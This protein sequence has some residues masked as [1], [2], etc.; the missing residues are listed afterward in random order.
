MK[1]KET[2]FERDGKIVFHFDF[3]DGCSQEADN[4]ETEAIARATNASDTSINKQQQCLTKD[5]GGDPDTVRHLRTLEELQ[6][7]DYERSDLKPCVAPLATGTELPAKLENPETA[8]PASKSAVDAS[9]RVD[10]SKKIKT[11]SWRDLLETENYGTG[12]HYAQSGGE[13]TMLTNIYYAHGGRSLRDAYKDPSKRK[14]VV[15]EIMASQVASYA[16]IS[17]MAGMLMSSVKDQAI[18]ENFNTPNSQFKSALD[19][20]MR[21]DKMVL[22]VIESHHRVQ[23]AV[24]GSVYVNKA[25]Q[26]NL[27]YNGSDP[28]EARRDEIPR[29]P[30]LPKP[31]KAKKNV[32]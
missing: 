9:T 4:P 25:E 30:R 15:D 27:Q 3:D 7:A 26:V 22:Q 14:E 21:A 11:T 28:K 23:N 5:E 8:L 17:Q 18:S 19:I 31:L 1:F 32:L 13:M 29:Q 2:T 20:K 6:K 24:A 12:L 10:V 16:G